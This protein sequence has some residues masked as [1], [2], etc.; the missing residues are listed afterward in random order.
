M[1][2]PACR[3]N[4]TGDLSAFSPRA[5]RSRMS[6][7]ASAAMRMREQRFAEHRGKLVTVFE[8]K[9]LLLLLCMNA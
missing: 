5:T 3:I 1:Y 2:R 7:S 8:A 6:C 9:L 4:Q